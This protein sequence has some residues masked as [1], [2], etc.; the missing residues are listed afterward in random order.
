METALR[1][2]SEELVAANAELARAAPARIKLLA[3]MS[4]DCAHHSMA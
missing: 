2:H 3:S 1:D 4:H